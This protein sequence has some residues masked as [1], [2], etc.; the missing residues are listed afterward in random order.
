[1][2]C[3]TVPETRMVLWGGGTRCV[4]DDMKTEDPEVCRAEAERL[5]ANKPPRKQTPTL[6][7]GFRHM[8]LIGCQALRDSF[9]RLIYESE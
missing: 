5:H 1:M 2:A 6:R 4:G 8:C 9:T 3:G 7:A